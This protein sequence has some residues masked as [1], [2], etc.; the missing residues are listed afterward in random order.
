MWS[1]CRYRGY[2]WN[3]VYNCIHCAAIEEA[4]CC[5]SL[6]CHA[7]VGC[8]QVMTQN[9]L[10][11]L[12][13]C[14]CFCLLNTIK[15]SVNSCVKCR[16]VLVTVVWC[17]DVTILQQLHW[18][19]VQQWVQFKVAVL[20]FQCLSGSALTYL[21]EECHLVADVCMRQLRST[22][23][24][25]CVVQRLHNAFSDQCFATAGLYPPNYNE[26]TLWESWNSALWHF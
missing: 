19:P 25:T 14:S 15:C 8:L 12:L 21:S 5:L 13:H 17:R 16:A 23:R 20:V 6:W 1:G 18:L 3:W 24:A 22:D 2:V 9:V 26:T 4:Y 11:V 10:T 7:A